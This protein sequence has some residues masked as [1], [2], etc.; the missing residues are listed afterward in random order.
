MLCKFK[1]RV[2]KILLTNLDYDYEY[3][4]NNNRNYNN[5]NKRHR[6]KTKEVVTS[7]SDESESGSNS[8]FLFYDMSNNNNPTRDDE[9]KMDTILRNNKKSPSALK[10]EEM[11]GAEEKFLPSSLNQSSSSTNRDSS[12]LARIQNWADFNLKFKSKELESIYERSYLS[13]TRLLFIKYLF[14]LILFTLTWLVYLLI[15]GCFTDRASCTATRKLNGFIAARRDGSYDITYVV[16]VERRNASTTYQQSTAAAAPLTNYLLLAYLIF[17]AA[18]Y[19]LIFVFLLLVELNERR[20]RRLEEQLNQRE[21]DTKV[22][23]NF[24]KILFV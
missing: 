13:V 16:D 17:M 8:S 20:Y 11:A 18:I 14:Y 4:E 2:S 7:S 15:T 1:K 9:F 19:L 23:K 21:I 6:N 10:N 3:D 12:L 5:N 24:F 22:S